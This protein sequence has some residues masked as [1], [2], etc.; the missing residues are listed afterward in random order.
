MFP[1]ASFENKRNSGLIK[2]NTVKL[3][4]DITI[5][6]FKT[7]VEHIDIYENSYIINLSSTSKR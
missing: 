2:F 7:D 6:M 1:V 4:C 3:I 5:I